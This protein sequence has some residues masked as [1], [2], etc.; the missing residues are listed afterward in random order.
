MSGQSRCLILGGRGFIGSHLVDSL[1]ARGYSVR[2]FGRPKVTPWSRP[3][4]ANDKFELFE[5]NFECEADIE[6]ALEGCDVCFHLISTTLPKSSNIDPVFDVES[7]LVGT[8]RLLKN[9]IRLGLRKIIFISSGGTIYGSPKGIPISE[10]HPTNPSCSY[11]ITKLAIEKYLALFYELYGLNYCVLRLSNPFGE[12][13]RIHASQGAIAVFLGKILRNETIEVWGDGSVVRDYIYISD[14]ISA[15]IMAL[16]YEGSQHIF[17]IASG[18]GLSLNQVLEAMEQ[19]TGR[20]IQR[21]YIEARPFDVPTSILCIEQAAQTLGW[22]P[23]VAFEEGLLSFFRWL[24]K[25]PNA[26]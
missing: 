18:H 25:N 14:V 22:L 12:R 24:E 1:L 2:C 6:A 3:Y 11:G 13:Q 19:V 17:N 7:N 5:G 23:T 26:D 21:R 10:S 16:E 8:I 20:V 9:G 4:S 15:L